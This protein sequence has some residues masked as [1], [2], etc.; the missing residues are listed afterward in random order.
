MRLRNRLV[1]ALAAL[2]V[3]GVAACSPPEGDDEPA[4]GDNGVTA[5]EATSAGASS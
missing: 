5:A 1:P 2:A 3:L 4:A